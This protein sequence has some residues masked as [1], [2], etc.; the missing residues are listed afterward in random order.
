MSKSKLARS[1]PLN[2]YFA[3]A[4]ISPSFFCYQLRL[5]NGMIKV[6]DYD[7]LDPI[8]CFELHLKKVVLKN[9]EGDKKPCID[10]ANFF[11]LNAEVLKLM[12]I[13]VL[14]EE[15]DKWMCHQHK[16]LK[17]ENRASQDAHIELRSSRYAIP[18]NHGHT[19]DLSLTDPFE[20]SLCGNNKSVIFSNY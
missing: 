13:G 4:F 19:H 12:E 2:K 5:G 15:S 18:T 9:Y 16:K 3:T 1:D 10:F 8:E 7:P 6:R 17:V 11:I 14:N 20:K